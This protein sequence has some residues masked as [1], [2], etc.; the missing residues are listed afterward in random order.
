MIGPLLPG[1]HAESIRAIRSPLPSHA[2]LPPIATTAARDL[3]RLAY[4]Q[5][6]NDAEMADCDFDPFT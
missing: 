6:V 2:T 1:E 4:W 3:A 5:G